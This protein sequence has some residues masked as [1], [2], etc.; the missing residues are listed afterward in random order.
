MMLRGWLDEQEQDPWFWRAKWSRRA[1]WRWLANRYKRGEQDEACRRAYD[2]IYGN[3]TCLQ[4]LWIRL[5][6]WLWP[7]QVRWERRWWA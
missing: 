4:R 5:D 2:R 7:L 3:L 1:Y 6:E